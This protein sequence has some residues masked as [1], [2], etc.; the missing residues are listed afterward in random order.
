MLPSSLIR[1]LASEAGGGLISHGREAATG[2]WGGMS[3]GGVEMCRSG[4]S[5][6]GLTGIEEALQASCRRKPPSF[7]LV[8][9]WPPTST[10]SS[11]RGPRRFQ[12]KNRHLEE[13]DR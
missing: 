3:S 6:V 4:V 8:T 7:Q 13:S 10:G 11:R 1:E 2:R 5:I 12:R 9:A